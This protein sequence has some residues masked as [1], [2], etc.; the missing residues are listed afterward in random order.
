MLLWTAKNEDGRDFRLWMKG[1]LWKS[2]KVARSKDNIYK[3]KIDDLDKGYQAIMLEFTIDPESDF[4]LII[5]TGPYVI[6]ETYPYKKYESI[7]K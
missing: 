6:P 7:N 2:S 5:S 4:P 3:I 1:E